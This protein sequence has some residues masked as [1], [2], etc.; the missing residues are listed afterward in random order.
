MMLIGCFVL[1]GTLFTWLC[2]A[3]GSRFF[4]ANHC[5]PGPRLGYARAR[6][7]AIKRAVT[8]YQLDWKDCPRTKEAL[9]DGGY[10]DARN[11]TDP[12]GK[13]ISFR[14]C[15]DGDTVV[16][17]GPDQEFGTTDDITSAR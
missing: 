2:G 15:V 10:L 6:V 11:F 4:F 7:L 13:A 12:W 14:C 1:Y 16:S 9:I 8:E 3:I 5:G 17:A